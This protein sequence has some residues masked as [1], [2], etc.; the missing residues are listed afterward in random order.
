MSR[1][2]LCQQV[3]VT[4]NSHLEPAPALCICRYLPISVCDR[5]CLLQA[6]VLVSSNLVPDFACPWKHSSLADLAFPV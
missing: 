1:G 4:V 6:T 5:S 3:F 2:Q